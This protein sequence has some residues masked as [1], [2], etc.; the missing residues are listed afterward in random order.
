MKKYLQNKTGR[1]RE[2]KISKL[3]EGQPLRDVS[4]DRRT[5]AMPFV[6]DLTMIGIKVPETNRRQYYRLRITPPLQK[7]HIQVNTL[8]TT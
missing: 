5:N 1:K 2:V 7:I 8:M 4:N 6:N 3:L